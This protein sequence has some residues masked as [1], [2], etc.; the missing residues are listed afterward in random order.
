MALYYYH[1]DRKKEGRV[2][3]GRKGGLQP[4]LDEAKEK[5]TDVD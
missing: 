2:V 5:Q 4:G 1:D 3:S